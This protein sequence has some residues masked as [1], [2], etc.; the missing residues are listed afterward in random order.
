MLS[1]DNDEESSSAGL[2]APSTKTM[3]LRPER[4]TNH[5]SQGPKGM[6]VVI[7]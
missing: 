7:K 1:S 3:H 4:E 6:L 5:F 2:L